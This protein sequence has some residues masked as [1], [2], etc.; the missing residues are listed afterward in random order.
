MTKIEYEIVEIDKKHYGHSYSKPISL[1]HLRRKGDRL[2]LCN[3][4]YM[5]NTELELI[6][7]QLGERNGVYCHCCELLAKRVILE[8]KNLP[9]TDVDIRESKFDLLRQGLHS[10]KEQFIDMNNSLTE[11]VSE[12]PKQPYNLTKLFT[13]LGSIAETKSEGKTEKIEPSLE[14]L[15]LIKKEQILD[16]SN[17]KTQ[18]G[19]SYLTEAIKKEPKFVIDESNLEQK[20]EDIPNVFRRRE[21]AE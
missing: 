4:A 18:N 21:R 12:L 7:W 5:N 11:E 15:E 1:L 14:E 20:K 17:I 10:M 13:R 3:N 2:S 16:V 9:V 19:F 6:D 8:T